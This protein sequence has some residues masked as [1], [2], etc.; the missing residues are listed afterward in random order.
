MAAAAL[1]GGKEH[2]ITDYDCFIFVYFTFLEGFPSAVVYGWDKENVIMAL[3]C[4]LCECNLT[5]LG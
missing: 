2:F 5:F 1:E 4:F 3:D